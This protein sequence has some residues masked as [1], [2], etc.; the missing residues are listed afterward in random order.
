MARIIRPREYLQEDVLEEKRAE[1]LQRRKEADAQAE[2]L[3]LVGRPDD[4]EVKHIKLLQEMEKR[5]INAI[6]LGGAGTIQEANQMMQDRLNA[7][8]PE[9]VARQEG[10]RKAL[11]GMFTGMGSS[12]AGSLFE[13]AGKI[14][15]VGY[16]A[17]FEAALEKEKEIDLEDPYAFNPFFGGR[18]SRAFDRGDVGWPQIPIKFPD[19]SAAFP[20]PQHVYPI[21][22]KY[23]TGLK[24]PLGG[25]SPQGIPPMSPISEQGLKPGTPE[26]PSDKIIPMPWDGPTWFHIGTDDVIREAVHPINWVGAVKL[27]SALARGIRGA[28][29]R[30]RTITNPFTKWKQADFW[31]MDK[32]TFAKLY[33]QLDANTHHPYSRALETKLQNLSP[34][35]Q[36]LMRT[37]W[38]ALAAQ[39]GYS[40]QQISDLEKWMHINGK[41]A[42]SSDV[43]E[44]EMA[45]FPGASRGDYYEQ[46]AIEWGDE[47]AD[48][49]EALHR[50]N[51]DTL[52]VTVRPVTHPDY[53]HPSGG[54]QPQG[55]HLGQQWDPALPA[56]LRGTDEGLM[57]ALGSYGAARGIAETTQVVL[58]RLGKLPT[59]E[60]LNKLKLRTGAKVTETPSG[61]GVNGTRGY[62]TITLEY[63]PD[64]WG[65][66]PGLTGKHRQRGR[67][68]SVWQAWQNYARD[69]GLV[70]V[71]SSAVVD[72]ISKMLRL[73]RVAV[74]DFKDVRTTELARRV[75]QAEEILR[76]EYDPTM[77]FEET[78][79]ALGGELKAGNPP[80]E[81]ILLEPEE[82]ADIFGDVIRAWESKQLTYWDAFNTDQALKDL[83]SGSLL[84][85]AQIQRLENLYGRGLADAIRSRRGALEKIGE[86]ALDIVN[87]PQGILTSFDMSAP[88]RQGIVLGAGHPKEFAGSMAWMAK[89]FASENVAQKVAFGIKGRPHFEKWRR[90]GLYYA[91]YGTTV[92]A[93]EAEYEFMSRFA[94]TLP[95]FKMSSRAYAT[96]LNKLRWDVAQTII[97]SWERAGAHLEFHPHLIG[98][99][100]NPTGWITKANAG[101]KDE[102]L[103]DLFKFLNRATGRGG[104]GPLEPFAAFLGPFHFSLR[105]QV[106]RLQMPLS[107]VS[108]HPRVR[109]QAARDLSAFFGTFITLA[110]LA[111]L[112]GMAKV[113]MN[114][115][116][117]NFGRMKSGKTTYDLSGGIQPYIRFLAQM[118]LSRSK[119]LT[120]DQIQ[121]IDRW[122]AAMHF[123]RTKLSPPAAFIVD[124][125]EGETLRGEELSFE[126]PNI[127]NYI[128][129]HVTPLF[130]QDVWDA[131]EAEGLPGLFKALPGFFGVTIHTYSTTRDAINSLLE[132]GTII[133]TDED[134]NRI[135]DY[136]SPKMTALQ[137]AQIHGH[138]EVQAVVNEQQALMKDQAETFSLRSGGARVRQLARDETWGRNEYKG[139]TER[140]RNDLAFASLQAATLAQEREL[141]R[142]K[143]LDNPRNA[144]ERAL[145]AWYDIVASHRVPGSDILEALQKDMASMSTDELQAI[146]RNYDI[147]GFITA[148]EE[149][150]AEL[151]PTER[152]FVLDNSH[153]N[154]T[155]YT[156]LY[157]ESQEELKGFWAVPE[158]KAKNEATLELYRKW[159]DLDQNQQRQFSRANPS[160]IGLGRQIKVAQDKLRRNS[161][162]ID[163]IMVVFYSRKPVHPANIKESKGGA[164]I[165]PIKERFLQDATRKLEE[166]SR[167][168]SGS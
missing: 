73:Q 96:F 91:E 38:K 84:Q 90:L 53:P 44:T 131:M 134:G 43:F 72:K 10:R 126:S 159:K 7:M 35:E 22:L 145:V 136:G 65:Q 151:P 74:S 16:P 125:K 87:F 116:S 92:A 8:S 89:A 103:K 110:T 31:N 163:T 156:N 62:G 49:L 127:R 60:A 138:P 29:F 141:R 98:S 128:K 148:G 39:R 80:Y 71:R 155:P 4:P 153:P 76:N 158:K 58:V 101:V 13:Q 19:P 25:E 117:T 54:I 20:G 2:A 129:E 137:Y 105:L 139:G 3:S 15:G 66:V 34:A 149:F 144:N 166:K 94:R 14:P 45:Q 113:E 41:N 88:F 165:R 114:P 104:L 82:F 52:D 93:N 67:A 33:Y 42:F 56:G 75:A 111:K 112:S 95:G 146:G 86:T 61:M 161:R 133:V 27:P 124:L 120:K 102:E 50:Q 150:M 63:R 168:R 59:E 100:K 69:Q 47:A 1:A 132:D 121:K 85:N 130:A 9:D 167:V 46:V 18:A 23:P 51:I 28:F 64:Q 119:S 99:R 122:D 36:E 118:S 83:F 70:Y 48:I 107:L 164:D 106:S 40:P 11:G 21:G 78:R 135:L 160:V 81:A 32:E 140:W 37:D 30:A 6:G 5:G 17:E 12:V 77:A 97:D 162:T 152:Q 24:A 123:W 142:G 68:D 154:R 115:L 79:R 143:L 147:E 108:A 157:Y 55:R 57:K 26:R 109:Q